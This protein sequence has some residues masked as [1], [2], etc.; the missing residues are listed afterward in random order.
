MEEKI[1]LL[2]GR[3]VDSLAGIDADYIV[4]YDRGA[5]VSVNELTA[6]ASE[7]SKKEGVC[8]VVSRGGMGAKLNSMIYSVAAGKGVPVPSGAVGFSRETAPRL[9]K[10]RKNDTTS[11]IM[12]AANCGVALSSVAYESNGGMRFSKLI[13]RW[14]SLFLS[15]HILKYIFSSVVAFAVD[16]VLLLL[17]NNL[18]GG[19]FPKLSMEIAALLAWLTSS[20]TN[21]TIN[22]SFVFRS[23][24]RIW[25]ALGEYYGLAAVVFLLKT[26][27]L[28]ELLT[29][30][31]SIPLGIAKPI[32]EV[33]FFIMNYFIQKK[34]IFKKR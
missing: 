6:M 31:L 14:W 26:Y 17:L 4:I 24:A 30:V 34:L 23:K 22:R 16:Y 9:V 8:A 2:C 20:I 10:A 18:L 29:R 15:S 25:T 12:E 32:A 5:E 27:V 19:I 11:L 7:M 33:V 28:L 13:S 21:F 1:V 3:D